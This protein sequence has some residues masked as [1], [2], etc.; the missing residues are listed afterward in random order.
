MVRRLHL[1]FVLEQTLGHV[2]HARNIERALA[3]RRDIDATVIG[4]EYDRAGGPMRRVPGLRNWSLRGSWTARGE[5]RRR[6]RR[7]P[8][9][10]VFIHTQVVSLLSGAVMREVPT[11]VSLDATPVNFDEQGAAYG[12][13]RQAATMERLKRDVNR[14]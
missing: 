3:R 2:A 14:R 10:A 9:D 11:V 13:R 6:L 4:V 12:H 1:A 8:L 5:L 7:G